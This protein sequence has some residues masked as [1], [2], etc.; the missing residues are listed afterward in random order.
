M[1]RIFLVLGTVVGAAAIIFGVASQ[2]SRIS[3]Q[4]KISGITELALETPSQTELQ[5]QQVAKETKEVQAIVTGFA[6]KYPNQ[7]GIV[8]T[9]LANGATASVND[10]QQMVA[11]SLYKLFVGYGIYK[12]IDAGQLSPNSP[13][14]GSALNVSQCLYIMI[15]ISDNDCGFYLGNMVGWAEL[16]ADLA[17]LGLTQTKVNNYVTSGSG[18]VNGDKL[19]SAADVAKFTQ[20]LYKGEL[21]NPDSTK[22]Y[23]DVLK[24]TKLN[25]WLP[26]GLPKGTVIGHKTGALYNLVH[27]AGIIYTSKGDYLL[28]VM[29]RDWENATKQPPPAFANISRLLWNYFTG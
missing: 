7:F 27:D 29:S 2:W 5:K 28:V 12:K 13:T 1:K 20:A 24:A 14:K 18:V 11:A 8:V 3:P 25:T 19:T 21:L 16:D 26:S 6:A 15:T 9:D 17:R 10:R 23:I 22:T 4:F